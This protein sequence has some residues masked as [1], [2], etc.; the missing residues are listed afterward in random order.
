[1]IWAV[2]LWEILSCCNEEL[3]QLYSEM[4]GLVFGLLVDVEGIF[5]SEMGVCEQD[6]LNS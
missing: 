1:M 3:A 6:S 4:G 5:H 2:L